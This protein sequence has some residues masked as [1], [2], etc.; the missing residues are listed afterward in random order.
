MTGFTSSFRVNLQIQEY[1][2]I[3]KGVSQ[4]FGTIRRAVNQP[5]TRDRT[6]FGDITILSNFSG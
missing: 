4:R 5:K 1:L 6:A 3:G 2:G